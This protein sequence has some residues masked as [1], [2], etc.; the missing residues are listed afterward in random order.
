MLTLGAWPIGRARDTG[1]AVPMP[2]PA[3]GAQREPQQGELNEMLNP[4]VPQSYENRK[5][6]GLDEHPSEDTSQMLKMT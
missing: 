6:K 4:A 2:S 5:G 3:R 1:A